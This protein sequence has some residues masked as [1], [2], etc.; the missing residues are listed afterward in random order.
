MEITIESLKNELARS[1]RGDLNVIQPDT[2]LG[3]IVDSLDMLDFYMNI[4][5][6][7]NISIP[8]EDIVKL[9][10][11]NNFINYLEKKIE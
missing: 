8:D 5:E 2:I 10:T 6:S 4:E 11:L 3:E 1:Y 9:K 7:N